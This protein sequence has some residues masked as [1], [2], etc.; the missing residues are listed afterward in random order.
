MVNAI[1]PR[2]EY[3]Y[4]YFIQYKH[5][6]KKCEEHTCQG[7][8]IS[9]MSDEGNLLKSYKH[10]RSHIDNSS[11]KYASDPLIAL[12]TLVVKLYDDHYTYPLL[13]LK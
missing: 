4:G 1:H 2:W 9:W 8:T 7:V 12:K 10:I 3:N 6:A 13:T 5:K 11:H